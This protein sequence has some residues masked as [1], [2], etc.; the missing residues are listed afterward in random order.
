MITQVLITPR[1][2]RQVRAMAA[3]QGLTGRFGLRVAVPADGVPG[4]TGEECFALN[5]IP[6]PE[7]DDVI[8]PRYGFDL[9]LPRHQ[10]ADLDGLRIDLGAADGVAG[11]VVGR[12]RREPRPTVPAP[13]D[14][15]TRAFLATATD[16][17]PAG[18]AELVSPVRAALARIRPLLQM[19]GGDA[20]LV[21]IRENTAYVRFTGACSGCSALS[22]TVSS[23]VQETICAAVPEIHEI[24]EVP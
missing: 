19:D 20:Q 14:A 3:D 24:T 16:D 4:P 17:V 7:P 15:G 6:A 5:L 22:V 12:D 13:L 10:A 1:A 8:L 21:G 9:C 2:A 23:T 11:F 18:R